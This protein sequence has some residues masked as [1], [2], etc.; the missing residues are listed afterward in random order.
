MP[1]KR[2]A[3]EQ[4]RREVR[5]YPSPHLLDWIDSQIGPGRRY[6]NRT[7]AFE[8]GIAALMREA[9]EQPP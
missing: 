6:F 7:H 3:P 5:V 4:K 2:A 1:R 8:A 9:G